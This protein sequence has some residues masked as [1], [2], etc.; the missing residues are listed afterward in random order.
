M[1]SRACWGWLQTSLAL[2]SSHTLT[3]QHIFIQC[4]IP[5]PPPKEMVHSSIIS[6]YDK[7]VYP[8]ED[9]NDLVLM[10]S[11]NFY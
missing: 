8:S 2:K 11:D 3:V 10:S 5:T 7:H 6:K 4:T 1:S 9:P